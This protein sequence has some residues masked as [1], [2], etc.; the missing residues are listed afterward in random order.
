MSTA[1]NVVQGLAKI[2]EL[3]EAIRHQRR[4]NRQTYLQLTEI[5]V[6][7][8]LLERSGS[9]QENAKTQAL[10]ALGNLAR[11]D[12]N[13]SNVVFPSEEVILPL[14]QFLRSGT[15]AQKAN[16]AAA[17]RKLA[18]SNEDNCETIVHDGA[19]PLLEELINTG[20]DVQKESGRAA[21]EKLSPYVASKNLA[22]VGGFFRSAAM[23]LV[24]M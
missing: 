7:L 1:I 21:L 24:V 11:A 14:M 16:A 10:R 13:N 4:V 2:F 8:Q 6:E 17:L 12:D 20:D 9:L 23:S 18:S 5:H 19:I 3:R 15:I 22:N